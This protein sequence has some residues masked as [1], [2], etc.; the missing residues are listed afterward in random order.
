MVSLQ[1]KDYGYECQYVIEGE[2][3]F[4]IDDYRQ[5]MDKVH[6]IDYSKEVVADFVKRKS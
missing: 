6:G 4:V 1:C 2:I 3:D 5:H